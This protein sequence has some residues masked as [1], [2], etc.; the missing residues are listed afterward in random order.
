[1]TFKVF[2]LSPNLPK[3]DFIACAYRLRYLALFVVYARRIANF[4]HAV[5]F[6]R[7][8]DF[9][10]ELCSAYAL[11]RN[12]CR[13]QFMNPWF[14]SCNRKVAIHCALRASLV[15]LSTTGLY[16]CRSAVLRRI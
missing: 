12:S 15:I 10:A 13:R 14:N 9:I 8:A 3:A 2:L 1:L 7:K 11:Q 5:D 16:P 6:I 4:I